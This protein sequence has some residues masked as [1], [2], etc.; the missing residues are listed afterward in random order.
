MSQCP[1]YEIRGVCH[2][3]RYTKNAVSKSPCPIYRIRLEFCLCR[4]YAIAWQSTMHGESFVVRL[5]GLFM[6]KQRRESVE[7]DQ[8]T[9]M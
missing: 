1:I 2:N 4:K 7:N 3:V 8:C 9:V 6:G 5:P